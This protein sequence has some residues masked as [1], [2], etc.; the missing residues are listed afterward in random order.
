LTLGRGSNLTLSKG[1]VCI[2]RE[3]PGSLHRFHRVNYFGLRFERVIYLDDVFTP[4]RRKQSAE[5]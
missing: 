5:A 4:H 2:R 1:E 3:R